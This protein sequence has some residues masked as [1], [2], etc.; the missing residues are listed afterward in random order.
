MITYD[1][2]NYFWVLGDST[3]GYMRTTSSV[4]EDANKIFPYLVPGGFFP[5][6]DVVS[7]GWECLI[8]GNTHSSEYHEWVPVHSSAALWIP[9]DT[10]HNEG[11]RMQREGM[12]VA[13]LPPK[14][15]RK[16]EKFYW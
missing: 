10:R 9:L 3:A 13:V 16:G 5:Y 2:E 6:G 12:A 7:T 8:E 14:R 1:E 11:Y 4:S 15:E